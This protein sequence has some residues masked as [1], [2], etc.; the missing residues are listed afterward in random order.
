MRTDRR[1]RRTATASGRPCRGASTTSIAAD[2]AARPA[3]RC[4]RSTRAAC[5]PPRTRDR[6]TAGTAAD[7][8]RATPW[9]ARPARGRPRRSRCAR[10]PSD[11]R[12]GAEVGH[13]DVEI[14]AASLGELRARRRDAELVVAG[15]DVDRV[16]DLV[17]DDLG[18]RRSAAA[19]RRQRQ[20]PFQ[21]ADRSHARL[22]LVDDE[23]LVLQRVAQLAVRAPARSRRGA[24]TSSA[25]TTR[26]S[27]ARPPASA[28]A[29]SR[30][31][32][33]VFGRM[34]AD[35]ADHADRRS[36]A[37]GGGPPGM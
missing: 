18:R 27:S 14:D 21:P 35:S 34:P 15:R 13:L 36:S 16:R 8:R 28:I 9:S 22:L 37:A 11:Q 17:G 1:S 12:R 20:P 3:A 2:S 24:D 25:S 7:A 10:P 32:R 29:V 19:A 6:A 5:R 23:H 26:V 4:P 30:N 33:S 31:G